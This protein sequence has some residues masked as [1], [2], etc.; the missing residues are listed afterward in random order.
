[1]ARAARRSASSPSCLF[2]SASSSLAAASVCGAASPDLGV[3][4]VRRLRRGLKPGRQFGDNALNR[5]AERVALRR[6][7]AADR[8][9]RGC[10]FLSAVSVAVSAARV[11]SR[12]S[13]LGFLRAAR[14]GPAGRRRGT[15]P[16]QQAQCGA[17]ASSQARSARYRL[18]RRRLLSHPTM[19]GPWR[20]LGAAAREGV[21]L[22]REDRGCAPGRALLEGAAND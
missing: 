10:R 14:P 13:R 21:H 6:A 9:R 4:S 20:Q 11:W 5:D 1:M 15:S 19:A 8:C 17:Q 3:S 7:G 2:F 18:I 12:S 16:G 22:R